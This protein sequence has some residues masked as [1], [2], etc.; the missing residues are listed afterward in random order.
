MGG[1]FF[2]GMEVMLVPGFTYFGV[3]GIILLLIAIIYAFLHYSTTI[4]L[5]ILFTSIIIVIAFF[6][7]FFKKGINRGFALKERENIQ[8]GFLPYKENYQQFT[9]KTG[10]AHSPLRPAGTVMIDDVKLS[11]VSQGDYIEAGE[12]IRVI[13]VEGNKL[14]VRKIS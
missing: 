13:K 3:S 9:D 2:I 7:W 5:S 12:K 11:A 14:I 1:I 10:I 8:N 6:I 4:A